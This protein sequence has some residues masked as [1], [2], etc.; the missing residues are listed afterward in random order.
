MSKNRHIPYF[1]SRKTHSN[2][3]FFQHHKK[4]FDFKGT[5]QSFLRIYSVSVLMNALHTQIYYIMNIDEFSIFTRRLRSEIVAIGYRYLKNDE[6]AEDNAQ[7]TLLKLWTIRGRLQQCTS[8]EGIAF[9]ICKN[10][11]ISKLRKRKVIPIELNEEIQQI[12]QHNAQWMLEEKENSEWLADMIDDLPASQM[13]ILKMSQQDG[14][15]NS[16]IA[17]ILGISE[18]TVRTAICKARKRLIEHLKA[19]TK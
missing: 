17:E 15:E 18:T 14:L 1:F 5:K 8:M 11:C 19:R 9:T 3:G 7:D 13:E 2:N 16:D 4:K 10:L 6:E 12:S